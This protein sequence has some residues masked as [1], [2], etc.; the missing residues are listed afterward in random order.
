MVGSDVHPHPWIGRT[1]GPEQG[2]GV[3]VTVLIALYN[4]A[5][6]IEE[7]VRSVL[8]QKFTDL[9]LLVVDD[10]STDGGTEKVRAI[11]DPRIRILQSEVNTGAAAAHNRGQDAAKGEYIAIM[12]ADDVMLPDRIGRQVAFM[13]A[14]PEIGLSGTWLRCF[15]EKDEVLRFPGTDAEI[16]SYMLFG[17]QVSHGSCMIRRAALDRSAVRCPENW[18]VPGMDYFFMAGFAMH[19]TMANI[20]EVL[21]LYRIGPQN[22]R[23]ARDPVQDRIVRLRGAFDLFALP[24]RD[25]D[26]MLLA[27]LEGLFVKVPGVQDVVRVRGLIH[28]LVKINAQRMLFPQDGFRKVLSGRWRLFFH[29][30]PKRSPAAAWIYFVLDPRRISWYALDITMRATIKRIFGRTG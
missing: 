9:E 5:P 26:A 30:L 10:A 1:L 25:D 12:G 22:M 11:D 17:L 7:A 3:K 15:G 16:R 27:M 13:D 8:D 29:E 21:T 19:T 20:D 24:M 23:H 18:R 28:R 14:H 2:N 4:K 6:Y